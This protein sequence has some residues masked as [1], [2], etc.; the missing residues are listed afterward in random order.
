MNNPSSPKSHLSRKLVTRRN[1]LALSG[2]VL[3]AVAGSRLV[4]G[5]SSS[6]TAT[7]S[8]SVGS[9]LALNSLPPNFIKPPNK[10]I[11]LVGTDGWISLPGGQIG[12]FHP[13]PYAVAQGTGKTTY[14]FGFR[15]VTGLSNTDM[16]A[17]KGKAQAP[18]PLLWVDQEADVRITLGNLGLQQ[19]PDLVDS[20]TIHW[21][22]FQN[23]IP[24]FDGVPEMSVAVPISRELTYFY[25]PHD[26]GTYMY[27]CHFEDVEHVQMGMV[28]IIFVKAA[29]N[30]GNSTLGIPAGKY[31]YNDGVQK[32]DP[33]SSYYDR[34]YGIFLNEVNVEA[35]YDD[36]HIQLFDW[37]EYK[38]DLRLMNG[39]VYPDT[40]LP[41]YDPLAGGAAGS[42]AER[43]QFQ[44]ISSLVT[45][46][47]GEKVLLRFVNLGYE[48]HVMTAPGLPFKVVGKDAV[49]LAG[50]DGTSNVYTTNEIYIGPGES[51]DV[52]FTAPS[53]TS[54][55]TYLLYNRHY[56]G[57]NNNGT[58]LGGQMTE[59]RV[60][61]SGVPTQTKP[62]ETYPNFL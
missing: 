58:G 46:N 14:I 57:L 1:F 40:L 56:A 34:E 60:Y 28:G 45:C 33:R 32:T 5:G 55:T 2:G 43:L 37:S 26:P 25:R 30:Q 20:H 18:A 54:K 41:N 15:D 8:T 59:I 48:Q 44:P 36:A 16:L 24:Y 12:G 9:R 61:P 4:P 62:N 49:Y 10:D 35:H 50:T 17:Q 11:K 6:G 38:P 53:V 21:H 29:Q 31:A 51:Y 3:A 13:D 19:R 27:H 39:R 42:D 7:A 22:G 47:S 52:I 23:A